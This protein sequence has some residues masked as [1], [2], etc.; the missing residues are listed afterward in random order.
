[1]SLKGTALN[2]NTLDDEN[3]HKVNETGGFRVVVSSQR[4]VLG[5]DTVQS[6]MSATTSGKQV[7]LA[8]S[9]DICTILRSPNVLYIYIY[10][11]THTYIYT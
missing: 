3:C 9:P 4:G 11:Y 2:C 5:Y 1:M 8:L 10:T 6:G 7:L